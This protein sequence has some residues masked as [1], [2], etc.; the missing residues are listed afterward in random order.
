MPAVAADAKGKA[1]ARVLIKNVSIFNGTS[2]TLITGKDVVLAGK[3]IDKIIPA[4]S[5][6]DEYDRVMAEERR[7]AVFVTPE[8]I[9]GNG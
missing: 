4:G 8:R 1:P 9:L 7:A 3:K 5:W 6:G 2:E